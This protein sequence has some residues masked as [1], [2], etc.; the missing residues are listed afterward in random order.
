M[1]ASVP[2]NA[3]LPSPSSSAPAWTLQAKPLPYTEEINNPQ[4]TDAPEAVIPVERINGPVLADCGG[5]DQVWASCSYG[6]AIMQRLDAHHDPHSHRLL[7]YPNA[8]HGVGAIVPN[9]PSPSDGNVQVPNTN[10]T[11][12]VNGTNPNANQTAE[13]QLWPQVLA[14]LAQAR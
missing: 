8:G 11:V 7:A 14:F 4:P 6:E 12:N 3:A 2:A 13:T 9:E 1:I 10:R 5:A